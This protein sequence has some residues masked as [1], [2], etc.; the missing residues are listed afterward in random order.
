MTGRRLQQA[1]VTAQAT[2]FASSIVADGASPSKTPAVAQTLLD[3]L[4]TEDES[5]STESV[6]G[7]FLAAGQ[8]DPKAASLTYAQTALLAAGGSQKQQRAFTASA[9]KA[10]TLAQSKGNMKRW[11]GGCFALG[12]AT[13][14]V[15]LLVT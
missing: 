14:A 9:A 10:F 3:Y 12:L 4:D 7:A 1:V 15:L 5:T 11:V 8:Q 6:A 2:A 13:H